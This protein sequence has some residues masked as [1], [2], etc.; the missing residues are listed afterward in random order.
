MNLPNT[1]SLSR[2]AFVPFLAVVLW[3]DSP[4]ARWTAL[5]LYTIGCIS[6][7]LDGYFARREQQ[8]SELGRMLDPV[9]DKCLI[10]TVIFMLVV[11][12]RIEGFNIIPSLIILLR[13]LLVS[14]LREFLA[15]L[16]MQ[17]HVSDVAKW[18]TALQ[19][20]A[21]G[22]FIVGDAVHAPL[23]PFVFFFGTI[24]LW[25]AAAIS[26]I[27]GFGYVRFSLRGI[28]RHT[29]RQRREREKRNRT[30]TTAQ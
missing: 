24:G 15:D 9:A 20:I 2:I 22:F 16:R 6:D 28:A 30:S 19:M 27:S 8:I 21:M 10:V 26:I 5:I 3:F 4:F 14:S 18:K 1:I 13:E 29:M 25:S 12:Q 7:F 23:V 11:T 17:M